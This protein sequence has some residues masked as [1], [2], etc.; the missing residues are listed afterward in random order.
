MPLKCTTYLEFQATKPKDKPMPYNMP[1][2]LWETA[3]ADIFMLNNKIYLCTV[4][5]HSKFLVMILTVGLSAN[6]LI[7][8]CKIMFA[9]YRLSRK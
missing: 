6:S 3:G 1:G 4:D 9:E 2:K 5:Y 8:I 7:E